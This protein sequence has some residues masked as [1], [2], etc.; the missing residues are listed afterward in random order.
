MEPTID[1]PKMSPKDFFVYL[2]IAITLYT[3]AGSLLALLFAI[4]NAKFV[5]VLSG[6]Y[7]YTSSADTLQFTI[8]SLIVVFPLYL[9]LSWFVRKDIARDPAKATLAIRKWF[10]WLTL[11]IA[12]A[13]VIGD[14]IALLNIYLG[15]EITIRF[16]LKML[17]VLA[18]AGGVFGYYF[19][20]MRR[21][22]NGNT[23]V[24]KSLIALAGILVLASIVMGFVVI[25][26][27]SERRAQ[28]FDEQRVSD[29]SGIQWE[30]LNYW[31]TRQKLPA[32][33]ADLGDEFSGYTAPVDPETGV[34]Y[35]Y[36]VKAF[37]S[38]DICATFARA[39]VAGDAGMVA[40]DPWGMGEA[41]AHEAGRT[42]F[43]RTIDSQKYPP[44]K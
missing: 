17:A 16:I 11:F 27:P 37:L 12:G 21:T 7:S 20:D 6:Y 35:E 38:F 40:R 22:A 15:G 30:V 25:G 8:S 10:T 36:T 33:L 5:D 29:L 43:T 31:Q 1:R 23:S 26:T 42:C 24:N 34:A 44:I 41:F 39:R 13:T 14:L 18:V 2:G 3:S 19:Y 32:S 9:T 28:R 4:I